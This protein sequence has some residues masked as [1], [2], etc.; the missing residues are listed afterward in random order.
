MGLKTA[1]AEYVRLDRDCD[2]A[3]AAYEASFRALGEATAALEVATEKLATFAIPLINE[4][5][6][7]LFVDGYAITNKRDKQVA[8]RRLAHISKVPD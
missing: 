5:G 4:A 6:S 3:I 8:V 1:L 7:G 2:L